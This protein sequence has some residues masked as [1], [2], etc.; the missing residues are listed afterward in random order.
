MKAV[1]A[2]ILVMSMFG[3]SRQANAETLM[4]VL[5]PKAASDVAERPTLDNAPTGSLVRPA[6][7]EKTT[8][9]RRPEK[10][11]YPDAMFWSFQ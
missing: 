10:P 5:F 11:S 8:T 3:L 2:A 4:D 1:L 7:L 9:D 6:N